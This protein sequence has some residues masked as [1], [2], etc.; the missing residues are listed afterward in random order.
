[1]WACDALEQ[2]LLDY[3]GTA[4]VVSHDRY[5]LNRVVQLLIVFEDDG[6]VQVI[7][8]N[9]DTYERMRLLQTE[10]EPAAPKKERD[11]PEAS[12]PRASESRPAKRKRRFPYRQVADIEAEIAALETWR[13]ELERLLAS[14]ELYRDGDKVQ[15]TTEAFEDT[16]EKLRQLYEQWEEAVE[17][18]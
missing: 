11:K 18:N 13:L 12:A 16:Q 3:E 5:F 7:H 15:E 9:Y 1:L 10:A 4:I 8:G 14:A 6:R 2:A 17:L